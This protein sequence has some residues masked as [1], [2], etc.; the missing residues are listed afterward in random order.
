MS[1]A[2]VPVG[3]V[4]VEGEDDEVEVV[5]INDPL[6][7][8][9][10]G[11]RGEHCIHISNVARAATV[12]DIRSFFAFAVQSGRLNFCLKVTAKRSKREPCISIR[13][14]QPRLHSFL[15]RP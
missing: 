14:R 13:L 9:S 8:M 3:S 2:S 11:E 4:V 10:S 5:A 7:E 1:A 6:T 12:E 15:T